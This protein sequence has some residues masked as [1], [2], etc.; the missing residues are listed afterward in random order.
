MTHPAAGRADPRGRARPEAEL[1]ESIVKLLRLHRVHVTR[2]AQARAS[3]V[4]EG[5]PDLYLTVPWERVA[6]WTPRPCA[7]WVEVKT[8]D[9]VLSEMQL[10]WHAAAKEAGVNVAVW[11]SVDDA[12]AW[13][14]RVGLRRAE[15]ADRAAGVPGREVR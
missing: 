11:R 7:W 10:A 14:G 2:L 9:G 12:L 1:Y 6:E 4:T 3:R 5:V 15:S 13:L 8:R